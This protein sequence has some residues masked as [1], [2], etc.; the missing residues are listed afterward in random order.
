MPY[1]TPKISLTWNAKYTEKSSTLRAFKWAWGRANQTSGCWD[2]CC[3]VIIHFIHRYPWICRYGYGSGSWWIGYHKI[4]W[5]GYPYGAL[6]LTQNGVIDNFHA[7][8]LC[9]YQSLHSCHRR[10]FRRWP[11]DSPRVRLARILSLRDLWWSSFH[12][13]CDPSIVSHALFGVLQP[14]CLRKNSGNYIYIR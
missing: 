7:F 12:S 9:S 2:I 3:Y 8:Q 13:C 10:Q 4:S 14:N 11:S 5:I 1:L 6:I